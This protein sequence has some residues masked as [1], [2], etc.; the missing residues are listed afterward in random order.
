MK[1]IRSEG[2]NTSREPSLL[3]RGPPC[4]P[5]CQLTYPWISTRHEEAPDTGRG[6]TSE[7]G[8]AGRRISRRSVP[9]PAPTGPYLCLRADRQGQEPVALF[10]PGLPP[11]PGGSRSRSAPAPPRTSGPP[12]RLHYNLAAARIPV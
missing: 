10:P 2:E 12:V 1:L 8:I 9:G 4:S 11:E 5:Q 6:G 3:T 7:S